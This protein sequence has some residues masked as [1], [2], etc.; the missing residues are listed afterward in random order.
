M[1]IAVVGGGI[2]GV[3]AALKL[4]K[5]HSVDLFEKN[6]DILKAA[7]G[8]NQFRLHSGYHYPRSKETSF[9]S[10]RA[11]T[12]FRNEYKEAIISDF[13]HFYCIAKEGSMTSA[14]NYLNFLKNSNLQ[15][16]FSECEL[17][18]KE[19]IDLCIK[20]REDFIDPI[21]LHSAC[22]ERL[23]NSGVK[24]FLNVK[25]T[26]EIFDKYDFVVVAT[27][28]EINSLF[29]N[30]PGLQKDYQFEVV[31]KPILK[32]PD[33]FKNRSVIILDGPFM[34]LNPYGR[35]DMFIMG[36]VVHG[37]H[38]TNVGK[39]PVVSEE[40]M[41]LLNNGIIKTPP[42]TKIDT[43]LESSAEFVPEMKKAEHVGS[44]FT[45]RTVFPYQEDTDARPTIVE[46]IDE[47]IATIF[48]GKIGN[49]VEAA[50]QVAKIVDGRSS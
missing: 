3:T 30:F 40:L 48:S 27:Y 47:K 21:K 8:I 7:S 41:P 50:E 28:S 11:E 14:E 6:T 26:K 34:N 15:F 43:I 17:V 36:H 2:F 12:T 22:W 46:S 39:L 18:A 4:A 23:N 33:N 45:I 1:K 9:S 5:N 31:E 20:V 16:T 49:C 35:T 42:I 38:Q 10:H 24:V 25:A 32:L 44:M 19:K 13:E 37:I 29:E